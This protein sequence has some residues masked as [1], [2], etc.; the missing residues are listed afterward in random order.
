MRRTLCGLLDLARREGSRSGRV[1]SGRVGTSV[2]SEPVS[3]PEFGCEKKAN[4]T[5]VKAAAARWTIQVGM[6]SRPSEPSDKSRWRHEVRH[7]YQTGRGSGAPVEPR[8]RRDRYRSGGKTRRRT[9]ERRRAELRAK[10]RSR[11][12]V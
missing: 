4:L 5:V 12:S 6:T 8:H 9:A 3:S 11:T 2:G 7:R 1:G 10:A